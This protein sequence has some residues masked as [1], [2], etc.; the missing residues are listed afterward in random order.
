MKK[1]I[2]RWCLPPNM[3]TGDVFRL[4]KKV[5][6]EGIELNLEEADLAA[7]S[8]PETMARIGIDASDAAITELRR[9]AEAEG[10]ELPSLSSGLFWRYPP[11]SDDPAIREKALRIGEQA[12]RIATLLGANT[13]LVVPGA[14]TC[15]VSPRRNGR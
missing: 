12:L 8:R 3:P 9:G 10:L 5:G 11:T 7:E 2:N 13:V 14:V 4:S 6:F 15:R 1:G